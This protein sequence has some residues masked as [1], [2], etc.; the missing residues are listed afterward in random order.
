MFL[1]YFD[2]LMLINNFLKIKKYYFNIFYNKKYLK[3]NNSNY[4]IK[5]PQSTCE[6]LL[7]VYDGKKKKNETN[8]LGNKTKILTFSFY[9]YFFT[10]LASKRTC[11]DI[12]SLSLIRRYLCYSTADQLQ[13]W[14]VNIFVQLD[15]LVI[16][17]HQVWFLFICFCFFILLLFR[18][19]Y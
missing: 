10:W 5:Y 18:W 17:Y 19:F 7:W 11:R 3:T 16:N 15:S 8:K 1:N 4:I 9:L 14:I 13:I 6:F 2:V 12:V